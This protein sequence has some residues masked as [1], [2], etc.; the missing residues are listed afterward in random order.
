MS[1][2][3]DDY[4][5]GAIPVVNTENLP[6]PPYI[7]AAGTGVATILLLL[8]LQPPFVLH[9]D[10]SISFVALLGWGSF[11]AGAVYGLHLLGWPSI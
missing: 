4:S 8:I 2:S 9:E 5:R 6:F 1:L 3:S 11:A 10:G 7:F